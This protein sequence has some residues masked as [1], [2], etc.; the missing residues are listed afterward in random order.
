MGERPDKSAVEIV[1]RAIAKADGLDYDEVCGYETEADECNS[2]TCVAAYY[3]DHDPDCARAGY[4]RYARA[5][6]A[7]F[8][9]IG[10]A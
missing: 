10:A 7:A 3:E 4:D 1:A 2:G 8:T 6:I 9:S 5:A